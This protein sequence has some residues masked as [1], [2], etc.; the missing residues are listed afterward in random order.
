[1]PTVKFETLAGHVVAPP[2]K[3]E[4]LTFTKELQAH[5]FERRSLFSLWTPAGKAVRIGTELEPEDGQVLLFVIGL[6]ADRNGYASIEELARR[7]DRWTMVGSLAHMLKGV[8]DTVTKTNPKFYLPPMRVRYQPNNTFYLTL[9]VPD[10][11]K[12]PL[13]TLN[14]RMIKWHGEGSDVRME[15]RAL[16]TSDRRSITMRIQ[17]RTMVEMQVP[18]GAFYPVHW[19]RLWSD[20]LVEVE[21]VVTFCGD[22]FIS[23]SAQRVRIV[24][25]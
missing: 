16:L 23:M 10:E 9:A 14:D 3:T 20:T 15:P 24:N 7:V 1:M 19:R 18:S 22:A 11:L 6:P 2:V 8:Y 21:A 4:S 5:V 17:K 25:E 13:Q 12:E